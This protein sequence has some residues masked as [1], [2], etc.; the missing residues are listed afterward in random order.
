MMNRITRI[1]IRI[2][3][4]LL[5]LLLFLT[6]V[7]PFVLNPLAISLFFADTYE[8]IPNNS[9][10]IPKDNLN[11][12][13]DG[14]LLRKDRE[15]TEETKGV[16]LIKEVTRGE[17]QEAGDKEN[18]KSRSNDRAMLAVEVET[19]QEAQKVGKRELTKT[20]S[21]KPDE[22]PLA[23]TRVRYLKDQLIGGRLF[24][25]LLAT[26]SN[27]HF[28]KELRGRMKDVQKALGD[29]TNDADLPKN[30]YNKLKAMDQT[31]AKGKQIH[32][33]CTAI[34]RKLRAMIYSTEEQLRVYQKQALFLTH[35]TAKTVPKGLH[36]LTLRLSTE[37]YS[38]NSSAQ[39]FP[40]QENLDDPNL[41]HYALFSDNVLATAVVVNS[42][43]TN[44]NDPSKHVFHIVTDKL[45]YAAMRMWFLVN[46]PGK[47]TI[48]VQNIDEFTWLNASYSP[49]LKRLAS[50]KMIDYYYKTHKAGEPGSNLKFQNPKY[51]SIMNHLR[52][53][54]PEIFPKLSKVVFL[55]DDIVVQKDLSGLWS[56][57]LKGKV[58]GAVETCGG[59]LFHRFDR[60]LNFLNP[61][62]AKNFD[63]HACGWAYGMNVFDLEEWKKQNITQVYHSW[64]N[65]N[66]ERQ[67][68]KLGTLPPGLI[69]FWKRVYT[70]EKSWHVLGL[71][72]NPSVSQKEIERAAV[73]HYNG[74]LK[75]WLEMG[76]PKFRGYWSRYVDYDQSYM[77]DCNMS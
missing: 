75:P 19:K 48:Q 45:N 76:I 18:V 68:W 7:A 31:L 39:Q 51:L 3:N 50:Q 47:A 46:P 26:R 59:N 41:F 70:L 52:F 77:R 66:N 71:G 23:D 44:A 74:N 11:E 61:I 20:K 35:L 10:V 63:P 37:Y 57:D 21:K 8:F 2:R 64:Q 14:E 22:H 28:I 1:T 69:T 73:I 67:L 49:V 5:L 32:D 72:Y 24:L 55:D 34:V 12:S 54:L 43:V 4:P 13:V 58:N 65:L 60:Y 33:D 16:F 62:I 53:Y 40:N 42:T 17:R 27:S 6:I 25:S 30:A 15:L 38:I 36:C 9:T 56:I 29:A